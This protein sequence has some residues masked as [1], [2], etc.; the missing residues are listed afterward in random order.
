MAE[1]KISE[2]LVGGLVLV[3]AAGF[4]LYSSGTI[5]LHRAGGSYDLHAS[6]RSAE[7]IAVGTD[8]RLAGVRVGSVTGLALNPQ[9]YFADMTISVQNGLELPQDTALLVS[10]EGLLGGNF[11]ELVP[12]GMPMNLAAGD[13]I[14]DTQGSVSL[15]SLL[16]KF[17]G[18]SA[19]DA[20]SGGGEAGEHSPTEAPPPVATEPAPALAGQ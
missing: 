9:T 14:V 5:G 4:L 7:G 17:V 10:S 18:G 16:M 11:M 20:L 1:T 13:E 19:S 6:F 15:I 12:G 8:V 3:V 2:V